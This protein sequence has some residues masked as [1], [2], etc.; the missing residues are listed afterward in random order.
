MPVGRSRPAQ[1]PRC[2]GISA[3]PGLNTDLFW[4]FSPVAG[5]LIGPVAFGH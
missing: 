3:A 4:Q 5:N 1:Y 2:R